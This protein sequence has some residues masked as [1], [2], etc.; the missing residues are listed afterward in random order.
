[1]TTPTIDP[2]V[3]SAVSDYIADVRGHLDDLDRDDRDD[4]VDGLDADLLELGA[5]LADERSGEETLV[6]RQPARPSVAVLLRQRVGEP[7]DYAR[8]LRAAAGLPPRGRRL[9]PVNER[10]RP[11]REWWQRQLE[12]PAVAAAAP[13]LR[14]I[15]PA[16]WVLRAWVAMQA[17][18]VVFGFY[19]NGLVPQAGG[20][21]VGGSRL[22][23]LLVF[24][25]VVVASVQI[26]RGAW[27]GRFAA[28]TTG[29]G[30]DAGTPTVD[31]QAEPD[32]RDETQRR[33][34]GRDRQQPE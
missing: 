10:S 32:Q 30:L 31:D 21:L 34:A 11:V 15:R 18:D 16:W 27:L 8:E 12:S 2:A 1:M 3:A 14:D 23:D 4:L 17:L 26:G 13:V 5:E 33:G 28:T 25:A 20:R 6:L 29:R 19:P 22:V 9:Y 24:A 7:A